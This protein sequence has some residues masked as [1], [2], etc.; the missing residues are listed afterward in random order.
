M[1]VLT[2]TRCRLYRIDIANMI[3]IISIGYL[4][5]YYIRGGEIMKKTLHKSASREQKSL[6]MYWELCSCPCSC[7]GC[8]S[9]PSYDYM[10]VYDSRGLD[11]YRSVFWSNVI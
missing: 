11:A 1:G 10:N 9:V 8:G 4:Y 7:S 5:K 2:L 3:F 6:Q